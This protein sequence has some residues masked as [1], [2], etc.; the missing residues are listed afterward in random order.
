MKPKNLAPILLAVFTNSLLAQ[1]YTWRPGDLLGGNGTWDTT[2]TNWNTGP[3][4]AWP[5]TGTA[6]EAVFEGTAGTVTISGGVTANKLTFNTGG[7]T[8]Q[9]STLSFNGTTPT[10]DVTTGTT[11][12]SS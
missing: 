3:Q 4:V 10:I 1:T 5:S 2:T 6:N 9:S 7:Y 11:T 8:V 12:I